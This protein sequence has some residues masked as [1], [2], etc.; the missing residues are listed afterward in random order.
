M[1]FRS[2]IKNAWNAFFNKD[3]TLDMKDY[4]A[5]FFSRP[6]RP[7]LSRRIERTII[8]A[9]FNRIA[10]DC[11]DVD[12]KHVQLDDNGRYKEDVDSGLNNCLTVEA[13]GD[14]TGRAFMQDV[15]M[16]MLDEGVVAIVPIDT[17][18][19]PYDTTGWDMVT[20]RTG[21]ITDWYPQHVKVECYDERD[22]QKKERIWPKT[23]VAIIENPFYSVM[24]ER[25]STMQ[26]LARK[27]SLLD[28]FDEKS[29]SNKLDMIIQLPFAAKTEIQKRKAEDRLKS[30]ESQL[31]RSHL[32]IG[33]IDATEHVTQL[34]RPVESNLLSQIDS[35]TSML[36]SQLGITQAILDGTADEKT[37]LNYYNHTIEPILSAIAE[38]MRRKFLTKNAR[39]RHQSIKFFKDP[40]KLVPVSDIAEIADKFTRNEI[41]TSNE[42][43]QVIGM[44]PSTDPAADQLKN[45]NMPQNEDAGITEDIPPGG[46]EGMAQSDDDIV[47]ELLQNLEAQITQIVDGVGNVEET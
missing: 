9:I 42:I 20:M 24:N 21:R 30:L 33:Y 10:V 39:T 22:G 8:V 25:N 45:S 11:A 18:V 13:N 35:L 37:M 16:S 26:R 6:D 2:R 7:I 38:E 47:E 46:Q 41:M 28:A 43:R 14:Q 19:D 36:Y 32:G 5:S 31:S 4:G 15:V 23:M 17:D 40:F 12:M 1:T 27:L 44:K 29:N 34:N 3:P